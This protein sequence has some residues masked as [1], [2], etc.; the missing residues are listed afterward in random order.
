MLH[1][2]SDSTRLIDII[3]DDSTLLS[4]ISRFGI[5]TGFANKTVTDVCR[6]T[7]IDC[8]TFLSIVNFIAEGNPDIEYYDNKVSIA[9]IIDYLKSCHTYFLA[10]K[11]PAIK[12]KL[13][14]L[15]QDAEQA[16]PYSKL[17]IKFFNEYFI[18]VKKHMDFEEKKVFP[19]VMKLMKGEETS[20]FSISKFEEHHTN[21]ELKLSELKDIIIR[22]YPAPSIN[23]MLNDV[24]F[25]LISC[26]EDLRTHNLIEDIFFIPI[27]RN[28]EQNKKQ[29]L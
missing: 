18:E 23:Y 16:I 8:H 1:K 3:N 5:K 14:I 19:Y 26:E 11:L 7:N 9:T 29:R 25:D 24:Y 17:F 2:Y 21:I 6:E 13:V 27:V 22:Y 10:Y 4:C 15:I 12:N 28:I 20:N